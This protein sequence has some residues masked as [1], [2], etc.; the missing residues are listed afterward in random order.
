[1]KTSMKAGEEVADLAKKSLPVNKPNAAPSEKAGKTY[2]VCEQNRAALWWSA[3]TGKE[4]RK[5]YKEQFK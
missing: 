1:M 3:K 2:R 5:R 4:G